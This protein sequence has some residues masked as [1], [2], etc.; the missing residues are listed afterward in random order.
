MLRVMLPPE[1]KVV[2]PLR[3]IALIVGRLLTT[4][5]T[6]FEEVAEH[7]LLFETTIL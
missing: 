1:Q 2:G 6:E 4:T 5:L 7:P 3:V